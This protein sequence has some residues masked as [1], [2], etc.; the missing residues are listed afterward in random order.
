MLC[1]LEQGQVTICSLKP[2]AALP[3]VFSAV[4]FLRNYKTVWLR[5]FLT[6]YLFKKRKTSVFCL[7]N[8]VCKIFKITCD[9]TLYRMLLCTNLCCLYCTKSHLWIG[10]EPWIFALI[11][12]TSIRLYFGRGELPCTPVANQV[13]NSDLHNWVRSCGNTNPRRYRASL[14]QTQAREFNPVCSKSQTAI[15]DEENCLLI[16]SWI[17]K[18]F[19]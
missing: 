4:R 16:F 2:G 14:T 10:H 9:N 13:R 5:L 19:P 7:F 12:Q 1:F 15:R 6:F 18:M 17:L 8:F 3:Q 11:N